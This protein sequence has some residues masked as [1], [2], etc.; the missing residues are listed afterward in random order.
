MSLISGIEKSLCFRGLCHSFLS[1]NFVAECRKISYGNLF[2]LYFRKFPVAKKFMDRREG[3]VSRSSLE[4]FLSHSAEKIRSGTL[5]FVTGFGYRKI[6]CLRGL[7]HDFPS[8]IF[9]VTVPKHFVEEPVKAVFQKTSGS[10]E[11]FG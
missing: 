2:V 7:C 4:D 3:E 1:N 5:Q 10:E 11:V 6:L 8:N 9:C